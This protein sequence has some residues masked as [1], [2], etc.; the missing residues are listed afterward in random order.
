MAAD[1]KKAKKAALKKMATDPWEVMIKSDREP[2]EEN[3]SKEVI[4]FDME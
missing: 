4:R 3:P 2:D 1:R